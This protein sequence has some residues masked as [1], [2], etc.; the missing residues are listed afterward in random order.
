MG[1]TRIEQLP[2]SL[3]KQ[4]RAR[5]LHQQ[6]W[7]RRDIALTLGVT[8]GTVKRWT[9]SNN[10]TYRLAVQPSTAHDVAELVEVI[11]SRAG[12][13]S[14]KLAVAA[15]LETHGIRDVDAKQIYG[16]ANVFELA[17]CVYITCLSQPQL[18]DSRPK[19]AAQ[20]NWKQV[21]FLFIGRYIG[22]ALYDVS[23][24]LQTLAL[25][26]LGYNLG[27]YTFFAPRETSIVIGAIILSFVVSGG[28]IRAIGY[29]GSFYIGQQNYVLAG[30]SVLR[31]ILLG[32]GT[33]MAV[34]LM[35]CAIDLFTSHTVSTS[36]LILIGYFA[37]FSG[38]LLHSAI[39]YA[40]QQRLGLFTMSFIGLAVVIGVMKY[41]DW[42][43]FAAHWLGML[44]T[45]L[46]AW[47]WIGLTFKA[48][49]T[50]HARVK[51]EL[52]PFR[53]Q[54]LAV[55]PHFVYGVFYYLFSTISRIV[56]YS[57]LTG[58][59]LRFSVQ[60]SYETGLIWALLPFLIAGPLL[61][62]ASQMLFAELA[63]RQSGRDVLQQNYYHSAFA[64]Y[65]VPAAISVLSMTVLSLI[66]YYGVMGLRG[67][68]N[69]II[70]DLF[71][72][73]TRDIIMVF[74]WTTVGNI[75]LVWGLLNVSLLLSSRK[76]W[77]PVQAVALASI[78]NLVVSVLFNH[79]WGYQY[80]VIG[81]AVGA[82]CLALV[83]FRGVWEILQ[84]VDYHD[85]SAYWNY[86]M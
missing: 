47:V 44:A 61:E 69:P 75:L 85:Y 10:E 23:F 58:S 43:I 71:S 63:E 72:N 70:E 24:I 64:A 4:V 80:S 55:A 21:S 15:L 27:F 37:L 6:G 76:M 38:I 35:F 12:R 83:T 36:T 53:S 22:A 67:I 9:K 34:S 14:D 78:V 18:P 7:R 49:S 51:N 57:H 59:P 54:L 25:L 42:G 11:T 2:R 46:S 81:F 50:S 82:L 56:A 65:I 66:A 40:L 39:M 86:S 48:K 8:S 45:L 3:D 52:P 1:A 19:Q 74:L 13:P 41:T 30:K 77:L 29:A 16:F 20:R 5:E 60:R 17:E 68:D 62:S 73:N 33:V 31:F 84:Q 79:L 32:F 26:G 28:F